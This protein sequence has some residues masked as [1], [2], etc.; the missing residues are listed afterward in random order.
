MGIN[1]DSDLV[2]FIS[3][4]R[5]DVVE[6]GIVWDVVSC[7]LCRADVP[8]FGADYW[9]IWLKDNLDGIISD[10]WVELSGDDL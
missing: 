6:A 2:N 4:A 1:N 7:V 10:N 9:D 3:S 5:S 8:A